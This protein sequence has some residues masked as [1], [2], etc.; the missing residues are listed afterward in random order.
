MRGRDW[1]SGFRVQRGL[2]FVFELFRALRLRL[3]ILGV[4]ISV[5]RVFKV[6]SSVNLEK[7]L[8]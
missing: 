2:G 4:R 5:L 6:F 7:L 3:G 1:F 8:I